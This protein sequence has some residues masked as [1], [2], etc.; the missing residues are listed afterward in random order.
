MEIKTHKV[1]IA[2]LSKQRTSLNNSVLSLES[3]GSMHKQT[4]DRYSRLEA[5]NFGLKEL[6]QLWLTI[7]EIARDNSILWDES[8][9]KFLKDIEEQYDNKLGFESKVQEK[10]MN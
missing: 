6:N 5:M 8:V 4:L 3:R 1:D 2:T 10:R 7:L 9:S